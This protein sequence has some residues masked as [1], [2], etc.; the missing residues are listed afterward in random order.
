MVDEVTASAAE[1]RAKWYLKSIG[2]DT[3]EHPA[4][5]NSL[6]SEFNAHADASRAEERERCARAVCPL[7]RRGVPHHT[8]SASSIGRG[9]DRHV[10]WDLHAV[11][12][13]GGV[14]LAECLA[15]A[16]WEGGAG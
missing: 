6:V 14:G 9:D 3:R 12:D 13:P 8:N 11:D 15:A 16:I 4:I 10:V 1:E 7:C 2:E 5:F